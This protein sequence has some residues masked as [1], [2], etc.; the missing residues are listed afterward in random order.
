MKRAE[1]TL[2]VGAVPTAST[3][4]TWG[5]KCKEQTDYLANL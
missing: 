1:Y 3:I 2:D 4:N 5:N